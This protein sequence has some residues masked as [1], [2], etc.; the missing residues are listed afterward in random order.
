[1]KTLKEILDLIFVTQSKFFPGIHVFFIPGSW[2]ATGLFKSLLKAVKVTGR[3][4]EFWCR[5]IPALLGVIYMVTVANNRN[6]DGILEYKLVM[7][8]IVLGFLLGSASAFFYFLFKPF[9]KFLHKK[10]LG[11][12]FNKEEFNKEEFNKEEFNKEEFNKEE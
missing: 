1:M 7:T 11:K 12:L 8:N 10:T 5:L 9:I 4:Y 3:W 2:Y 6:A